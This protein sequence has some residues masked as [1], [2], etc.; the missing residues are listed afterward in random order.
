MRAAASRR[1]PRLSSRS[2]GGEGGIRT[3]DTVS[4]IHAFQASAFSHSATSP[5]AGA[6]DA[7][8]IAR[9][10]ADKQRWS[11]PSASGQNAQLTQPDPAGLADVVAAE[12]GSAVGEGRRA[13]EAE[14][15]LR[16][17]AGNSRAGA[18]PDRSAPRSAARNRARPRR[19]TARVAMPQSARPRA[20]RLGDVGPGGGRAVSPR[21]AS[22]GAS[23]ARASS[24]S[25]S[26]CAPAPA[27]R[28]AMRARVLATDC[29]VLELVRIAGRDQ[30]SLLAAREGDQHR[31]VQPGR[32]RDRVDIRGLV[33]AVDAG[34]DGS[35]PPSPRRAPAAAIR[36][37][38]LPA[39]W[40]GRSRFRATPIPAADR[41]C[42]RRSA[43]PAAREL[44]GAEQPG[45]HP[46][47]E[48]GFREQPA[49]GDLAAGHGAVRR[50][51]HRAC[52]RRAADSAAASSVVSNSGMNTYAQI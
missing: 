15:R 16:A 14:Q 10:Q 27:G 6:C 43:A 18:A 46:A 49:A 25:S 3:L 7:R 12:L 1:S 26:S 44:R 9:W 35:R 5:I 42:R 32:V 37:R 17:A 13:H 36:I 21:S 39:G 28:C 23:P 34:A 30:Q 45:G 41:G 29:D 11:V 33:V 8:N 48:R 51:A 52:A 20:H 4:R 2:S 47:V 38:C 19:A 40:R 50:P 24:A 22:S 31:V